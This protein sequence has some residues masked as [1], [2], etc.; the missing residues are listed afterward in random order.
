MLMLRDQQQK[1][2]VKQTSQ[3]EHQQ[4]LK[5]LRRHRPTKSV[6]EKQPAAEKTDVLYDFV[7]YH[8]PQNLHFFYNLNLL[9]LVFAGSVSSPVN[10]Y[11]SSK[12]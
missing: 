5:E 1:Q 6:R 4:I 3:R 11:T 9:W 12:Y 10:Q 8:N 7:S 2:P